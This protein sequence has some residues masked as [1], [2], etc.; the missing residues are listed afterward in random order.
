MK[1]SLLALISLAI[2]F[3]PA[4]SAG[5]DEVLKEVRPQPWQEKSLHG[6]TSVKYS[7]FTEPANAY[8]E[9][10]DTALKQLGIP[11]GKASS[12]DPNADLLGDTEAVVKIVAQKKD[13]NTSWVGITVEQKSQLSRSPSLRFSGETYRAGKVCKTADVSKAVQTLCS[14]LVSDF[15]AQRATQ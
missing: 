8:T 3:T 5:A 6:I 10:I 7:A 2:L 15:K 4:S 14:Q 9:M 1:S 13:A 11:V 12:D